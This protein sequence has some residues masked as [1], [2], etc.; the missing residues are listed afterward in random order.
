MFPH[1]IECHPITLPRCL[2]L[3][4]I[5]TA[6]KFVRFPPN[7]LVYYVQTSGKL[8]NYHSSFITEELTVPFSPATYLLYT[9][10]SSSPTR[11]LCL[12][13]ETLEWKINLL[14]DIYR[15]LALYQR[16]GGNSFQIISKLPNLF[17]PPT[18]STALIPRI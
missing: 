14:S 10:P 11:S 5:T 9:S 3:D 13:I 18:I 17:P 8:T 2:M 1:H 7:H 12:C 16:F 6:S 4:F 15:A